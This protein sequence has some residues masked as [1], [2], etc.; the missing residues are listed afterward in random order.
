MPRIANGVPE[1]QLKSGLLGEHGELNRSETAQVSSPYRKEDAAAKCRWTPFE[2]D[3]TIEV[4]GV[5][6]IIEDNQGVGTTSERIESRTELVIGGMIESLWP[7]LGADLGEPLSERFG[8]VDPEN[9]AGVVVPFLAAV[10]IFDGELGL[11]DT[12][13][14][15]ESGRPNADGLSRL[16]D[17][18]EPLEVVGATDEVDVSGNGT[19]KGMGPAGGS[20]PLTRR[21]YQK[22]SRMSWT[23]ASPGPVGLSAHWMSSATCSGTVT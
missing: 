7:Q 16:K 23:A 15:G 6:K 8:G 10:N 3:R 12:P 22:F 21:A 9:A 17:G 11:A 14:A 1:Q 19:K 20:A 18:V 5:F 13:H 4:S 2:P